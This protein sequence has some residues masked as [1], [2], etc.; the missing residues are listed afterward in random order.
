MNSVY[1]GKKP[2]VRYLSV[3]LLCRQHRRDGFSFCFPP[4]LRMPYYVVV[5]LYHS[6]FR[7]SLKTAL[8]SAD[9]MIL[10]RMTKGIKGLF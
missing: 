7:K 8:I 9:K 2:P 6:I 1:P 10:A 4:L 3:A 5:L